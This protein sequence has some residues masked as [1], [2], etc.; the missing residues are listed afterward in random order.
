MPLQN[1]VGGR[2]MQN[3]FN[4]NLVSTSKVRGTDGFVVPLSAPFKLFHTTV[5][6]WHAH[7]DGAGNNFFSKRDIWNAE[8]RNLI[9]Y[10][11]GDGRILKYDPVT[12][13]FYEYSS[14]TNDFEISDWESCVR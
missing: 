10:V 11:S 8:D 6:T 5:A 13:E 9:T 12:G 1:E 2:V 3:W 4:P 14:E 7:P